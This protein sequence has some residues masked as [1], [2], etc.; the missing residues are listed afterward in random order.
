MRSGMKMFMAS[1]VFIV[2]L[3]CN[4]N[5]NDDAKQ[6][7]SVSPDS[8]NKAP[9]KPGINPYAIV[10]VSPMDMSYY[11]TD[12][13]KLKMA[14]GSD[15]PLLARVIYSRPHLQGRHLF[16]EML[17][18]GQPWRLGANE[19]TELELYR[20]ATIQNKIVKAG[21]YVMYCIPQPDNWTIILNSN[22]DSWGLHPDSTR[23]VMRFNIPVNQTGRNLEYFTMVF[24]K[25][26]GLA[27]L[28]MAWEDIEAR[29]P[30]RF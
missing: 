2:G 30:F 8:I 25:K 14:G 12:Y 17:Q 15:T 21:R 28:V 23:D 11:P 18:Y 27:E 29:L 7:R 3:S 26:Q 6:N 16:N 4:N 9:R 20:D 19:S 10:D 1:M 13:P 24:E 22:T 5:N